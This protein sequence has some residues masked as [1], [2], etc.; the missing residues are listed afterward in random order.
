[1]TS[2]KAREQMHIKYCRDD[3]CF[4]DYDDPGKDCLNFDFLLDRAKKEAGDREGLTGEVRR[5]RFIVYTDRSS[6][7]LVC[8][9]CDTN[10][11]RGDV[12]P[13]LP[14]LVEAARDH[15]CDPKRLEELKRGR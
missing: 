10:L 5:E 13:F 14:V 7:S 2:L 12:D 4:I 9:E 11:T 6:S 15:E 1:M 3:Q 8:Q